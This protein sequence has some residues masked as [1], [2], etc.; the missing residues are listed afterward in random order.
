MGD[1]EHTAPVGLH[2]AG[3]A[4]GTLIIFTKNAPV[5]LVTETVGVAP[6]ESV[7]ALLAGTV[8][9]VRGTAVPS[10]VSVE[11]ALAITV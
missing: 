3:P 10:L 4:Y 1:L 2:E 11:V 6:V 7:A 9:T 8:G 5:D